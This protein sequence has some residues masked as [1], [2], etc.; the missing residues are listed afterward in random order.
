MASITLYV[1]LLEDVLRS[2]QIVTSILKKSY[3]NQSNAKTDYIRLKINI[4]LH[5]SN[6]KYN[7]DLEM[8]ML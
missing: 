2:H 7:R 5:D 4:E 6:L 3:C 8:L 1:K